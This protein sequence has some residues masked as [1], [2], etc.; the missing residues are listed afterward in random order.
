MSFEKNIVDDK[1]D[2]QTYLLSDV[3]EFSR[4]QLTISKVKPA[5]AKYISTLALVLVPFCSAQAQIS[6]EKSEALP[7]IQCSPSDT[8]LD[9]D[10]TIKN[11]S[12]AEPNEAPASPGSSQRLN[13][14]RR[15]VA[16]IS[17]TNNTIFDESED[18]TMAFHHMANW[19]HITTKDD[20][21]RERL[22][23]K[24]GDLLNED[25][26]LEAE[27]IIRGQAY[28]RDVKITFKESCDINEQAQI[29]IQTWDNWSL[30]PTVSFGRK[31]GENKLSIGVKEDNVFGTGIRARFKYNSDEQRNGYQFTLRSPF[32]A[33]PYS[34]ILVDFADNDDGQLT[35][36]ELDKPFYHIN[37]DYMFN[38]SFLKNEKTEDVFQNGLTRNSFNENS[39]RYAI[40]GGW[41]L[42]HQENMSTRIE[43]GFVDDSAKFEATRLLNTADSVFLPQVRAYQYPWIGVEYVERKF[44]RMFDVYL[45]NQTEDINLG[46]HHEVKLGLELNDVAQDSDAGYHVNLLSSKGY[47]INDALVLLSAEGQA[48]LNTSNPDQYSLTGNLEYFSRYSDLMGMYA[49]FS[50]TSSKNNFLDKPFTVG[51]DSGVRG[52]P[53]QYQHGDTS[54]SSS[55]E[56]RFYTDYNILK[57][58]DLGF[59]AFADAG[60]AWGGEQAAFNETDSLLTSVGAG[61]RLYSSRSSH[62]SVVHMDIAKPFETSDNVDSWQWR[63]QIKQ[64][65]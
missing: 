37:S 59:V 9:H 12:K 38:L 3:V 50:G 34:T 43:F 29:E 61:V 39:H 57:I 5:L 48:H 21:I 10:L 44:K 23:F 31:G 6:V 62:K 56:A 16:K 54:F 51:D 47:E 19:M 36:L 49:R 11:H 28:I 52:Y 42:E 1:H 24:E 46:W 45:I 63:L 65:F 27:R 30:I 33:I 25:D 26:L 64:S 20:V 18:D 35:Q 7:M 8:N 22:P 41:Q 14:G 32:P 53:L 13:K 15:Q 55:L 17:I 40:S 4:N 58:L 2:S 60:K